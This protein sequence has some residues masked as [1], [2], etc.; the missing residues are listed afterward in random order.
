[1]DDLN[2][3]LMPRV[4]G[5]DCGDA[6][7]WKATTGVLRRRPWWRRGRA[8]L[9]MALCFAA[10]MLAM[11][12]WPK[13]EKAAGEPVM[14][15][16]EVDRPE[17]SVGADESHSFTDTPRRL[18]RWAANATGEKRRELLRKA[19]DGFLKHGDEVAAVRCYRKSL[20]GSSAPELA[21]RTDDTWLLMRLKIAQHK[22]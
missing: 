6:K 18:E 5:N 16:A 17:E 22:E 13:A 11:N 7:V 19:G 4:A 12:R 10:G 9:V 14:A 2:D 3:L 20:E 1:M 21:V 15:R 8:G